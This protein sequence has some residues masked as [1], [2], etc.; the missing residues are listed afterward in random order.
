MTRHEA[1]QTSSASPRW[2]APFPR[3]A[4]PLVCS[5]LLPH[6]LAQQSTSPSVVFSTA[7]HTGS[8]CPL[9]GIIVMSSWPTVGQTSTAGSLYVVAV[10]GGSQSA[11][12][13]PSP[14][15]GR[16]NPLRIVQELSLQGGIEKT[17]PTKLKLRCTD[18]WTEVSYQ[19]S[20]C[21]KKVLAVF[22]LTSRNAF[23]RT[24]KTCRE[25]P[26]WFKSNRSI[27]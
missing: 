2:D 17:I 27:L 26:N 24:R 8:D 19:H 6:S 18:K 16:T 12:D 10:H 9:S 25:R 5:F 22:R 1:V 21:K 4:L 20:K 3:R 13:V 11:A 14:D 15:V 23:S 7:V